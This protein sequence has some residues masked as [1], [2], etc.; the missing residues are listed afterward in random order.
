MAIAEWKLDIAASADLI[1]DGA[2]TANKI[3]AGQVTA[4]KISVSNLSSLS[5]NIGTVTAGT[6]TGTT[7]RTASDGS[8]NYMEISGT[9]LKGK[10]SGGSTIW[11][12]FPAQGPLALT[13]FNDANYEKSINASNLVHLS[14][15][16]IYDDVASNPN[17]TEGMNAAIAAAFNWYSSTGF[18]GRWNVTSL[19][20]TAPR[21]VLVSIKT[22]VGTGC[23]AE[24]IAGPVSAYATW[25]AP[26]YRWYVTFV[27]AASAIRIGVIGQIMD[28]RLVIVP[29][30]KIGSS[31]FIHLSYSGS[32][33]GVSGTVRI[34]GIFS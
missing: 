3:G 17:T 2:I 16:A 33:T 12:M 10:D 6:I 13:D 18:T 32:L 26:P 8:G 7:F 1:V 15:Y 31:L 24:I 5:A 19:L 20:P 4:T 23:K 30:Q 25:T 21:Y 11:E 28:T 29:V 14:S 9:S 34:V 22:T 27:Q